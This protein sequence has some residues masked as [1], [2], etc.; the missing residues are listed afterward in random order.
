MITYSTYFAQSQYSS[1]IVRKALEIYGDY[2]SVPMIE[3][4]LQSEGVAELMECPT[5]EFV[6]HRLM[7]FTGD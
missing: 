6:L 5:G 3:V 4:L 1:S 2:I 7:E